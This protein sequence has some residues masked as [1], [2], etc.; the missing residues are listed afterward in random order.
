MNI[1]NLL[2]DSQLQNQTQQQELF[3]EELDSP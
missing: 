2:V 1:I 3:L